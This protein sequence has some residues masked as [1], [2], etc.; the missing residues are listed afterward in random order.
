MDPIISSL[1]AKATEGEVIGALKAV[2]G[3]FQPETTF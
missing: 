1:R 3:E 2:Y